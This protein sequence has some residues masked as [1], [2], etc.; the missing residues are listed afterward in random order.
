MVDLPEPIELPPPPTLAAPPAPELVSDTVAGAAL[1]AAAAWGDPVVVIEGTLFGRDW[2]V[3]VEVADEHGTIWPLIV[4][5][6]D[7]AQN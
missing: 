2:K 3:L 6:N 5:V 7:A 1:D 4:S